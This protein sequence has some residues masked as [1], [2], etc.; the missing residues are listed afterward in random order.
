MGS[1]GALAI[2]SW[3]M[4]T[5]RCLAM[6]ACQLTMRETLQTMA[7]PCSLSLE[8]IHRTSAQPSACLLCF[9]PYAS[10]VRRPEGFPTVCFRVPGS[11]V[12]S[13]QGLAGGCASPAVGMWEDRIARRGPNMLS[14][15]ERGARFP[16][17][18]TRATVDQVVERRR[19][20]GP[21]KTP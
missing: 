4:T 14:R 10:R 11:L 21:S 5:S 3:L 19:C 20:P 18:K 6:E 8:S 13:N 7:H 9:N 2:L 16:G 12:L 1:S 15:R 17:E